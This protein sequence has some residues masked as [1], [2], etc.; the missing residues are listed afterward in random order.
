M[1]HQID[2]PFDL[3]R[4]LEQE[5]GTSNELLSDRDSGILRKL[6]RKA[7]DELD[8]LDQ[9]VPG[10]PSPRR[11]LLLKRIKRYRVALAPLKALPPELLNYIFLFAVDRSIS[12]PLRRHSSLVPWNIS[13]VCSSWRQ[14]ALAEP[15]LWTDI[16]I[17]YSHKNHLRLNSI[18]N[19]IIS[20]SR[21]FGISLLCTEDAPMVGGHAPEALVSQREL[22]AKYATRVIQLTMETSK[23]SLVPYLA[24]S[25]LQF[26]WLESLIVSIRGRYIFN[27]ILTDRLITLFSNTPSLR[28]IKLYAFMQYRLLPDLF[29]VP[30]G[31][32]TDLLLRQVIMSHHTTLALLQQCTNLTNCTLTLGDNSD[33]VLENPPEDV[34]P[35]TIPHLRSLTLQIDITKLAVHL[36][37]SV[38]L[39]SLHALDVGPN[40]RRGLIPQALPQDA[41]LSMLKRSRCKLATFT[42]RYRNEFDALLILRDMPDL[43]R[44]S[45]T[46]RY[47][48]DP[49][50]GAMTRGEMLMKLEHIQCGLKSIHPF[51]DLLEYSWSRKSASKS[52]DAYKGLMSVNVW[53]YSLPD[54]AGAQERIDNLQS[55]I[56]LEGRI[57]S[58]TLAD[59]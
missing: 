38:T 29:L 28:K 37:D 31:Q 14:I 7:N 6:L 47:L 23:A 18:G 36:M 13:Y 45:L 27:D 54:R 25:P 2:T 51:L 50:I 11:D 46:A 39:P 34:N 33:P 52:M 48:G 56:E 15:R 8:I 5:A 1:A 49:V 4:R 32:I 53:G 35:I 55:Q 41:I 26:S 57:V 12:L 59:H 17:D 24:T 16:A 30:W 20:R 19:Y 9:E 21:D 43:R 58:I 44:F 42:C 3:V 10:D 22:I 40:P